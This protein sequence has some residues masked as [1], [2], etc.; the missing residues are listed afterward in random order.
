MIFYVD[1]SV[2]SSIWPFAASFFIALLLY[3]SQFRASLWSWVKRTT[4][5]G[6]PK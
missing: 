2:R 6:R 3:L 1:F 4:N 5:K